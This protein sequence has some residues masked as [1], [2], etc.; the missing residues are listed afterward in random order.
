MKFWIIIAV[1]ITGSVAYLTLGTANTAKKK[2]NT[3]ASQAQAPQG[4]YATLVGKPAPDFALQSYDG[5]TISLKSM[6]GKNLVIFFSE[7]IGCYPACWNQIAALGTDKELN[8]DQI[9][10]LSIV[11]DAKE[12]WITAARRMPDLGK[13]T[14]LLD[15][16]LSVSQSY[17]MINL[18]SSMHQGSK[19]GHTY[20]VVDKNG[21]I[22]YTY[23]DVTMG[24][25]NKLLK[26]DLAKL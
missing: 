5:R 4:D 11:P 25:Q 15:P 20:V 18:G 10:T 16:T 13:E 22:R 24:V 26:Q 1:I 6:R 2:T 19:P 23:D 9:A 3:T 17:G 21:I 12:Q 8:T 14:L 7:G